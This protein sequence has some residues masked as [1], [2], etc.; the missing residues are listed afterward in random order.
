MVHLMVEGNVASGR[1]APLGHPALLC[2]ANWTS[3]S[4]TVSPL[5]SLPP[6]LRI[7]PISIPPLSV[8]RKKERR[9][10]VISSVSQLLL[11]AKK[12]LH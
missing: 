1:R 7:N 8:A 6:L 2:F 9:Y 11:K 5:S 4:L 10:F 12:L 3:V